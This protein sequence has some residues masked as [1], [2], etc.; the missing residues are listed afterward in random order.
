MNY[1]HLIFGAEAVAIVWLAFSGVG[2][3]LGRFTASVLNRPSLVRS[4][5]TAFGGAV[6]CAFGFLTTIAAIATVTGP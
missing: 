2:A 3:M 1:I 4:E 5:W 6:G